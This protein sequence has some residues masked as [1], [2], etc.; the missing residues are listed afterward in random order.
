VPAEFVYE[1]CG[2]TGKGVRW[3]IY[4]PGA[5]PMG[6]AGIYTQ[7][8]H[9]DDGRHMFSF[10]MLTVNADGAPDVQPHASAWRREARGHDPRSGR[11]RR[12]A[13]M[14]GGLCAA[15]DQRTKAASLTATQRTRRRLRSQC[16]GGNRGTARGQSGGSAHADDSVLQS[17]PPVGTRLARA[18]GRELPQPELFQFTFTQP[19]PEGAGMQSARVFSLSVA[20]PIAIATACGTGMAQNI[21]QV[22]A[23][24][25]S[26]LTA[27]TNQRDEAPHSL[28][29][30]PAALSMSTDFAKG[31]WVRLYDGVDFR[32]QKL[33]LVGPLQLAGMGTTSPE[34]RDRRPGGASDPL[35]RRKRRGPLGR[36]GS[37]TTLDRPCRQ[38]S[39][40]VRQDRVGASG[41]RHELTRSELAG[42]RRPTAVLMGGRMHSKGQ[43][44]GAS[45]CKRDAR[46]SRVRIRS[47][48]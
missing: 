18:R 37:S 15:S 10:A 43:R 4:Q 21:G 27:A 5:V 16:H 44:P 14:P 8:T 11:L 32:G 26:H 17:K 23:A 13:V 20:I 39:W 33:M 47:C 25:S 35:Q 9:S 29:V 48:L 41:M 6:I 46:M 30:V 22:G 36:A 19:E 38:G 45:R 42:P 3:R 2:E 28:V 40:V 31:C 1:P 12:V 34:Q 7:W 24:S